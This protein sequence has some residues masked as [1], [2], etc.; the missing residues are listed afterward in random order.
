MCLKVYI[1]KVFRNPN[2]VTRDSL[3]VIA[4]NAG[5]YF[6]KSLNNDPHRQVSLL[7]G[8]MLFS[9]LKGEGLLKYLPGENTKVWDEEERRTL[10]K[11]LT[12][13]GPHRG[14]ISAC[15]WTW[16][17][18]TSPSVTCRHV[19]NDFCCHQE[20]S[21]VTARIVGVGPHH[22][23]RISCRCERR[24]VPGFP[25]KGSKSRRIRSRQSQNQ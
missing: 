16:T 21:R 9:V 12:L 17:A 14:F 3:C 10:V 19:C 7:C 2:V 4:H 13:H 5:E 18:P 23:S 8:I 6:C 24:R 25:E 15:R 11:R 1:D 20:E 22:E